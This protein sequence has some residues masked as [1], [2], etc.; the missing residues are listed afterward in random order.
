MPDP[1]LA[2][3]GVFADAFEPL[4]DGNAPWSHWAGD[5]A[6]N[7]AAPSERRAA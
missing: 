3:D 1:S 7:G 2:T 5:H 6:G 4:G